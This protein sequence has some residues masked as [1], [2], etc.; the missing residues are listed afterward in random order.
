[1]KNKKVMKYSLLTTVVVLIVVGII[2]SLVSS[3]S[4]L[5]TSKVISESSQRIALQVAIPCQGH[6]S[7]IIN[8]LNKIE[9][10]EKVE[11]SP[12]STFTVY[13]NPEKTTKEKILSTKILQE[14]STREIN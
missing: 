7:L 14:Y 11:Y 8:E 10:V 1:M 5:T 12:I 2:Y 6:S 9:G 4:N 3:A 13:Y